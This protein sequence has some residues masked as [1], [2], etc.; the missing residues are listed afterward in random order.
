LSLIGPGANRAAGQGPR[1]AP[2]AFKRL[3]ETKAVGVADLTEALKSSNRDVRFYTACTLVQIEPG[4]EAAHAVLKVELP[5]LGKLLE[6]ED[7]ESRVFAAKDLGCLGADAETAVPIL[8][9]TRPLAKRDAYA[10]TDALEAIGPAAV[11]FLSKALKEGDN[12]RKV[13]GILARIGPKVIL[14]HEV[15]VQALTEAVK[16]RNKEIRRA[17]LLALGRP[18]AVW[19]EVLKDKDK[20]FCWEAAEALDYYRE[21]GRAFTTGCEEYYRFAA[22]HALVT[23]G[24]DARTAV[25]ALTEALKDTDRDVRFYA[26]CA[27]VQIQPENKAASAL[28][29]GEL[30]ALIKLLKDGDGRRVA[31]A[32]DVVGCLGAKAE[33]AVPALREAVAH[34][35]QWAVPGRAALRALMKIR[36]ATRAEEN[37]PA[38]FLSYTHAG[39]AEVSVKGDKL[40][41]IWHT[42]R[43]WDEELKKKPGSLNYD[44]H[45]I[46]VWLTDKELERFRDWVGRHKV[47]DFD[48]EYPSSSPRSS[49]FVSRLT[50][51]RGDKMQSVSWVGD[52]KRPKEL[53]TAVHE[54]LAL[55]GEIQKSR[56][57]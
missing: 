17:A 34:P 24:P 28:L 18:A 15:D 16:D 2:A 4:N 5:A 37:A 36:Q 57:R 7:V 50:V 52:R 41:Y 25:P 32:A 35:R 42:T 40:R 53:A 33:P 12:P 6:A 54:L 9:H 1:S 29:L 26:A 48:Q 55:A 21:R 49:A 22:A 3:P 23:V 20:D 30:R 44:R 31:F 38:F 45:E 43:H 27:L 39:L 51:D 13:V 11:P 19:V 47:F 46:H 10:V 14:A 56:T 8:F